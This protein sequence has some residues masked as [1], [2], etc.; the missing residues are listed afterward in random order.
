MAPQTPEEDP[1]IELASGSIGLLMSRL[2]PPVHYLHRPRMLRKE[3]K[4]FPNPHPPKRLA[5]APLP[6]QLFMAVRTKCAVLLSRRKI[7]AFPASGEYPTFGYESVF[8]DI[9]NMKALFGMSWA[10]LCERWARAFPLS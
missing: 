7:Y 3:T 8:G 4:R 5:P 1:L 10:R 2:R 9:L 6:S